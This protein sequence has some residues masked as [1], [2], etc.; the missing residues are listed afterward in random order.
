[1]AYAAQSDLVPQ[2]ITAKEAL[3]LTDD[4]NSGQ[5]D[6]AIIANA[7]SEASGTID[8]FCRNRYVTPLQ[9]SE[10]VTRLCL[11]IA[12][13]TLFSRRRNVK[14]AETVDMRYQEAMKMLKAIS[15]GTAQLDQ[16]PG[17]PPQLSCA[18]PVISNKRP[19]EDRSQR[20]R[21]EELKG[22]I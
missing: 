12:A 9:P 17:D 10:M 5:I 3:Q 19:E 14:M 11:D 13:W 22:F 4:T 20:F 1:M 15:A 16:P 18:G 6:A 7:L 8:S 2:R 21:D